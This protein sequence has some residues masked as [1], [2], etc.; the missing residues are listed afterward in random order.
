VIA[1]DRSLLAAVLAG[2]LTSGVA[3]SSYAADRASPPTCTTS[4]LRLKLGPLVSEKTEQHTAAFVLNNLE[5]NACTL[6]GYPTVTL[7]DSA[8]RVLPFAY[9]HRGDQMITAAPPTAVHVPGGGAAY[10]ELNKNACISYTTRRATM[11]RV[12][13]PDS[14]GSLLLR[15]PHSPLIDYCPAGDP[16]D[17]ITLS[18][19]EPTPSAAACRSQRACGPAARTALTG[20]LPPAGTVLGTVRMPIRE[21]ALYTARGNTLFLITFPEQQATS[22]T[23][24]RIDSSG[25]R[26][27]RLPFPLAYYLTDLSAGANGLYAGTSVIKRFTNVPDVLL[28]INPRTLKVLARASFPARVAALEAGER[29]WASIGDGRV[30][31]LDP[32]TLRVLA[33]RRLL[34]AGA[35]AMQG[36]GLS[37]PA[38]G[39]GSLWVMAGGGTKTELVRMDPTTLAVRSRTRIPPGKPVA[40]VIG[41]VTHVYLVDPG[42]AV[43]DASGRLG[44]VNASTEL[45]AAAVHDHGLVG[46]NDAK[47]AIELLNLQGRVVARTSFRDLG[48]ELAVSGDDAW[49]LG[50]AGSGNGIVHVRLTK[51][52]R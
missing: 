39:L 21:S 25:T 15:L 31:R 2:A 33:T 8:G 50:N 16:G 35:V 4:Q 20:S 51:R 44:H 48:G 11:I 42:I 6:D 29:M 30:V 32:T 24:E 17:A 14:Q 23:I 28:R 46:L 3:A 10:L 18:P 12:G 1:A 47:L 38:F 34:P 40:Q 37:K 27:R 45:D 19:I 41:D 43:V 9:G 52:V 7:L 36:L 5:R 26:L 13:L 49:F 22:I